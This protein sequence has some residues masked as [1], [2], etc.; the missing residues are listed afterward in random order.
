MPETR[1][2][3]GFFSDSSPFASETSVPLTVQIVKS[4]KD[5]FAVAVSSIRNP[6]SA[7]AGLAR[8]VACCR[9]FRPVPKGLRTPPCH[10]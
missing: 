3:T 10:P 1:I 2:L 9:R 7:I 6:Q 4:R 8:A 5:F